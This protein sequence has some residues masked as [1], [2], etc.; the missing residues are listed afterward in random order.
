DGAAVDEATVTGWFAWFQ[1]AFLFGAAAGGWVFGWLG[2]RVGRVRSLGASVL[3]YTLFTFAAYFATGLEQHLVLRFLACLGVG[4]AWRSGPRPR[5]AGLGG[6]AAI[7]GFVFRG[8]VAYLCPVTADAWKWTLLVGT[9]PAIVG[10]FTL[11][12]V[13]ESP[14]WKAAVPAPAAASP[15]RE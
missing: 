13:P 2:D 10:V 8:A 11:L 6:A 14:R 4:G 1:A 9:A 3:C 12:L 5:L 7:F 15:L